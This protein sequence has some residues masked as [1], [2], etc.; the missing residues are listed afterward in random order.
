MASCVTSLE[1]I[2]WDDLG[3]ESIKRL[4]LHELPLVVAIDALGNDAFRQGQAE[5]LASCQ[6]DSK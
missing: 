6:D 1:V 3:P 4:T 5:Y 2:C